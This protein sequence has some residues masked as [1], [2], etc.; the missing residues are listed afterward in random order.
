MD[1]STG[2]K[3]F[4]VVVLGLHASSLVPRLA[5]DVAAAGDAF[6]AVG[7]DSF[8]A[9]G[10]E[11]SDAP[12]ALAAVPKSTAGQDPT[13]GGGDPSGCGGDPSGGGCLPPS[14]GVPSQLIVWEDA[15]ADLPIVVTDPDTPANQL[16]VSATTWDEATISQQSLFNGLSGQ[17]SQRVLRVRPQPNVFGGASIAVR[18]SDGRNQASRM[19]WIGVQ[20]VNDP[21]SAEYQAH[22]WHPRGTVGPIERSSYA[23]NL[24]A[25]PANEGNQFVDFEILDVRDPRG[26]LSQSPQLFF[27]GALRYGLSGNTGSAQ[28]RLRPVDSGGNER[29]GQPFGRT[30]TLRILAGRG[31]DVSVSIERIAPLGP[32]L[33]RVPGEPIQASYRVNLTNHGPDVA[34]QVE[35]AVPVPAGF[36]QIN[37][38]CQAGGNATCSPSSGA[39]AIQVQSSLA[40]GA[41]VR[42][43]MQGLIDPGLQFLE[44]RAAAAATDGSEPMNT[45]DDS[46]TL[47]DPVGPDSLH[48]SGF[49]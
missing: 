36:S 15:Q 23:Y 9:G 22:S 6:S 16:T 26:V 49:E 27:S 3:I 19:V 31:T 13:G 7:F 17:G 30:H 14:I 33:S 32:L 28:V 29:G 5:N 10:S 48:R 44:L 12:A 25:G 46:G 45:S 38:N 24:S 8:M 39:G 4:S 20:P 37:W 42:V 41:S 2:Q 43:E 18:V 35:L 11:G 40:V 34:K 21:P 47:I 1:F